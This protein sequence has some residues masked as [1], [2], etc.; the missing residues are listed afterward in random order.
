MVPCNGGETILKRKEKGQTHPWK[1][2]ETS[3][4][5]D[6]EGAWGGKKRELGKPPLPRKRLDH[7]GPDLIGR[8][9]GKAHRMSKQEQNEANSIPCGETPAAPP[10]PRKHIARK[11]RNLNP[12]KHQKKRRKGRAITQAGASQARIG[13]PA[14]NDPGGKKADR[15]G[16]KRRGKG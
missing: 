16:G 6:D 2:G 1:E 12:R 10:A 4:E 3:G 8:G 5:L 11:G 7:R 9:G 15:V 13:W 14:C